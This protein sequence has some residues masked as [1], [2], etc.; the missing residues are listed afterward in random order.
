LC[1][2]DADDDYDEDYDEDYYKYDEF[3]NMGDPI[4]G[5]ELLLDRGFD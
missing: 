5:F 1:W 2:T 3:D 4:S